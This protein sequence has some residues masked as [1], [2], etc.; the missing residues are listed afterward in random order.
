FLSFIAAALFALMLSATIA[1]AQTQH[2]VALHQFNTD[3]DGANPHGALLMD[4]AGNLFGTTF[5]GGNGEGT[6]FK[7]DTTGKETVL[8]EF[9]SFTTGANPATPLIQDQSGNLYGIA[10]GGPGAGLIFKISPDGQETTVF[11]FQGGEFD[12]RVPTGGL[13]M[14]KSGNIFGTTL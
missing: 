9:D 1:S 5:F 13:F 14:D 11:N 2:F 8:F 7:I 10:D 12:P 4:A 6:V 3:T